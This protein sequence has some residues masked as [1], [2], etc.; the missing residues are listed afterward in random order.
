VVRIA[1]RQSNGHLLVVD[2][3]VR[4]GGAVAEHV[5]P[6]TT[7]TFTVVRG[8]LGVRHDG[9]ELRRAP[10]HGCGA[11]RVPPA[12]PA[13]SGRQDRP[14]GSAT[15]LRAAVIGREFA[16]TIRFTTLPRLAERLLIGVLRRVAVA[17]G[18]RSSE[19][20]V[21]LPKQRVDELV[22]SGIGARFDP[23]RDGRLMREWA[24]IPARHGQPWELLADEAL[25]FVNS[26]T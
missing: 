14:Q 24:T 1:P 15:S 3:Y 6:M 13:R 5:H 19:L 21:K 11:R 18:H 25:R 20:V 8:Q 10:G 2:L 9:R 17:T 12:A 22:G 4:P 23:R 7:E 26:A 16:D